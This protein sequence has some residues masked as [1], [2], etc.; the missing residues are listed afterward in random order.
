MQSVSRCARYA[1]T[2]LGC[3]LDKGGIKSQRRADSVAMQHYDGRQPRLI[4][5]AERNELTDRLGMLGK[6]SPGGAERI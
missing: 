5:W 2:L 4:D 1:C 3:T 6:V